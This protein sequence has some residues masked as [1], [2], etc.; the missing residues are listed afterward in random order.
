MNKKTLIIVPHQDDEINVAGGYIASQKDNSNTY[1]LYTT[2]GDFIFDAKYRYKEALKSLKKLG[3]ITKEN[4]IFLGYSDQAYDQDTHM[5]NQK[6]EWIS[7]KEYKETYAPIGFNEWNYEQYNRHCNFNIDNFTRNIKEVILKIKPEIIICVDLDF[8]PDHIMTSLCTEKAIGQILKQNQEYK[9]IIFKTFAYE[10]CYFGPNDFFDK[11][12]KCMKF[13]CDEHGFIKNNPYY[14]IKDGVRFNIDKG[15]YTKKKK[16][17]KVFRAIL[18]HKSQNLVSHTGRI[19]NADI[20]YWQRKTNNLL[21]DSTITVS[22]GNA[23]YLN[24]FIVCDTSNVLNGNN[25]EICYNEGIWVP[26]NNDDKKEIIIKF[27]NKKYVD[28]INIYNGRKNKKFINNI[29]VEYNKKV[30]DILLNKNYLNKIYIRDKVD[31]IK[32]K[33]IDKKVFNGFSE[34]EVFTE[35]NKYHSNYQ[36][37]EEKSSIFINIINKGIISIIS[38]LQKVY[39]KIFIK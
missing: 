6:D 9:P 3:N 34:I 36:D 13:S 21:I 1:I 8:H 24:D 33:V 31:L 14:N 23:S 12:Y 32:I 19:I 35:E 28:Y 20:V 10:N 17:N 26:D 15:C 39:R 2:N 5:Y 25:R 16:K 22:S 37:I 18:C 27:K 38:I 11:E 30:D 29:K 4:V 7:K